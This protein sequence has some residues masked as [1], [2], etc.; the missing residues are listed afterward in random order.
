MCH[1]V[2]ASDF[3]Q[4]HSG[5]SQEATCRTQIGTDGVGA[6]VSA[7]KRPLKFF[8]MLFHPESVK[9]FTSLRQLAQNLSN[10]K[11]LHEARARQ[12]TVDLD[13]HRHAALPRSGF[14]QS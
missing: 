6:K 11:L 3:T 5:F 9:P 8:E 4:G 1:D 2:L 7:Q 12:M 14:V 13:I 10:K